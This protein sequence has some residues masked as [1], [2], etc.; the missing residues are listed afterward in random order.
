MSPQASLDY[1]PTEVVQELLRHLASTDVKSVSC[2]NK[3]LREISEPIIFRHVRFHFCKAGFKTL[4]H[5][6]QS[7][8]LQ[9][10]VSFTYVFPELFQWSKF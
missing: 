9:H 3:R 4:K 1:F 5:F 10:V 2:S 6:L 7:K 8:V